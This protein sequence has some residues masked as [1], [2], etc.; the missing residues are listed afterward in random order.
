MYNK[1]IISELSENLRKLRID[2]YILGKLGGIQKEMAKR[3]RIIL[4][5]AKW[6]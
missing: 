5:Q 4:S 6:R 2:E 3:Q 1:Y